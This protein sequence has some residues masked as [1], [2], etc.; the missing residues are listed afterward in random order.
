[1]PPVGKFAGGSGGGHSEVAGANSREGDIDTALNECITNKRLYDCTI[2]RNY[3]E[4]KKSI[5]RPQGGWF[6][7]RPESCFAFQ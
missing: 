6:L 5:I 2:E 3:A 4:Q 1:M 7:L